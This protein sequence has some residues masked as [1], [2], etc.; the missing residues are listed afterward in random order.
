MLFRSLEGTPNKLKEEYTT[1]ILRIYHPGEEVLTYLKQRKI[2]FKNILEGIEMDISEPIEAIH[3]LKYMEEIEQV[4][5]FE[6]KHGT[7]DDVF[8][9]IMEE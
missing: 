2:E 7:I 3:I 6:M 9:N 1:D 4:S 5:P 8:L